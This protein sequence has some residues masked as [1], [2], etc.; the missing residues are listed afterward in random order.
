MENNGNQTRVF[1]YGTLKQGHGNYSALK[2]SEFLG[3]CV[4]E[5]EY[6]LLDLGWYPGLVCTRSGESN[7][8]VYGE[9]YKVDESTLHTLDL[10]EGHPSFYERIKVKT[11]WKNTWVYTLPEDYISD[12]EIVADG[13]WE[14]SDEERAFYEERVNGNAG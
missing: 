6:T 1:V 8:R 4:L 7:G 14:P 12:N 3:R 13:C 11:P 2:D 10:I 5:G 9:V